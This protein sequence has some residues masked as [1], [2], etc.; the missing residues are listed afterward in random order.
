MKRNH[1]KG[2]DRKYF[3]FLVNLKQA[4]EVNEYL[5]INALLKEHSIAL[6]VNGALYDLGI[7]SRGRKK[8]WLETDPNLAMAQAVIIQVNET[9]NQKKLIPSDDKYYNTTHKEFQRLN[10]NAVRVGKG[11]YHAPKKEREWKQ[12]FSFKFFNLKC[13]FFKLK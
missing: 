6:R 11:Y 7:V 8:V 13:K 4:I 1:R 2:L 9:R 3:I 5:S 10:P 12:I